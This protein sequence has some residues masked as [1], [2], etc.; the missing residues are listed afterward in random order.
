MRI[1]DKTRAFLSDVRGNVATI[2]SIALAPLTLMAGGAVDF[3]QAMGARARLAEALDA[4]ALAVGS[5]PGLDE[6]RAEAMVMDYI[7]ANYPD[8]DP[9]SVQNVQVSIDDRNGIVRV[10]GESEVQTTL[11]G[12]MG[13]DSITVDWMSEVMRARMNLELVMVL[14]NTGS[15]S[16]SK[17]RALRDAAEVLTETLFDG[18]A[19]RDALAIGL[20]PFAATVNVGTQYARAWWLDPEGEA[21]YHGEWMGDRDNGHGND[22]DGCDDGNPG[23]GRGRG[24]GRGQRDP[25]S[26]ECNNE[27]LPTHWDLFDELRNTSWA[28]CVEA[29][30][31]PYD[32][33]DVEPSNNN[34]ETLFVPYFAPDEP[35]NG[36][37]FNSYLDD[38]LSS[39]DTRNMTALEMLAANFAR[40]TGGRPSGG[41]PNRACTTQP[42][43]PMTNDQRTI[44][45]AIRAMGASGNTNIPN[46]I[47]WGT[48]LLSPQEPFTEGAPFGD[49][50][51]IKA[52][53]ILTDGENV[54]SGGNGNLMSDYN[55]YG[56]AAQGRLGVQS[57]SG[58]R[59]SDALD[60]RTLAACAY[61][62]QQ[63]IRV[64]TI[65][66]QVNSNST[67]RMM[68]QCASHP[69]LYFDS[70]SN[71]A[72]RNAFE[73]IAGDLSNL[74]I[75]R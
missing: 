44:L 27:D 5:Q 68:E 67:R 9:G 26:E 3:N 19:D 72:L 7:T 21:P 65:T 31:M 36:R 60:E 24:R 71:E 70:P 53:V 23:L 54:I 2:F 30:P 8:R 20:V 13:M 29:R 63:G 12:L 10:S 32:I 75:S 50:E 47:A 57:A 17:I 74:R 40:Y 14:D 46:G 59:L 52:M 51:T 22:A 28:G 25:N 11:L 45:N 37:Y 15:M 18:A 39:R 41:S 56:Y 69:S 61:A 6:D 38:G 35:D 4:A 55:A 33:E 42:V 58:S 48:R 64:Y 73:L 49:R 16:G 62:R 43:T 1:F 34:P 66:F